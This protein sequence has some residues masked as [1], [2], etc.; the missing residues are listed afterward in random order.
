MQE[1]LERTADTH[2]DLERARQLI[3]KFRNDDQPRL[4][5]EPALAE[6][7]GVTRSR[8][9]VLLKKLEAEKLIWRH[10]G[11][12]TFVGERSLAPEFGE[13]ADQVNP[14]EA[15]EARLVVEPQLAALAAKRATTNQIEEMRSFLRRMEDVTQY[16]QWAALDERLHRLVATAASNTLLL[17][18]YD[19]IRKNAPSGMRHRLASVLS[20]RP[21]RETDL[22]HGA[23]VEAIAQGD[24]D[25]AE[26][27]MRAH[28]ASVRSAAFGDI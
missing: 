13:L 10:V 17:A 14:L 28:I 11:K 23:Y 1:K 22:E 24:P 20:V 12:G 3:E 25:G 15:L 4:P 21:R 16:D 19:T 9:R 8:L 18:V 7:L 26:Q 27:A 5:P 2:R 6:I